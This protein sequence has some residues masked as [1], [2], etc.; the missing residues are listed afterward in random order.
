MYHPN[1][2][3]GK[4]D[5]PGYK[6]FL[7]QIGLDKPQHPK[8]LNEEKVEF[9]LQTQYTF[10]AADTM[11]LCQF[12]FGPAWQ[13]YGP[14]EMADLLAGATGWQVSVQDIQ[15]YGRRRLNLMRA[16]NARQGLDR[17]Q[18]TLPKKL[19]RHAL[20]GGRTDGVVLDEAEF[21]TGIDMYYRQAGWD[22][23]NGVPTRETLEATGLAWAADELGL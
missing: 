17:D 15:E 2:F 3:V 7:N 22:S 9:A 13:M 19:F 23:E 8:A 11:G 20:K 21:S 5:R 16:L 14:Q 18:D 6:R 4:P 10:S 12:V 1:R